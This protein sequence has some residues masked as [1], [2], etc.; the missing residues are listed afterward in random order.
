M[1]SKACFEAD[2]T[3]CFLARL[4]KRPSLTTNL[5]SWALDL[6][7]KHDEFDVTMTAA[8][9]RIHRANLDLPSTELSF[10]DNNRLLF[11]DG[12][13][14]DAV[15]SLGVV[16]VHSPELGFEIV[17]GLQ[18]DSYQAPTSNV[19]RDWRLALA[20]V[21]I[22]DSQYEFSVLPS[23]LDVVWVDEAEVDYGGY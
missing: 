16:K 18:S 20:R 14:V 23:V 6:D 17:S 8:R 19:H 10:S 15:A 22:Q 3:L 13:I 7:A 1:F 2:G 11:C 9:H 5:P 21:L 12:I 4:N